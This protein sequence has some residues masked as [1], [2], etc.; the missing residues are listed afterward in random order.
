[1][2][3][4]TLP[5]ASLSVA[6]SCVVCPTDMVRGVGVTATLA[7]AACDTE[8]DDVPFFP[9]EVA[10][11]VADPGPVAGIIPFTS[12][13][14]TAELLVLQVIGRPG[15][16]FCPASSA[17]AESSACPPGEASTCGGVTTTLATGVRS[18]VIVATPD[19]PFTLAATCVEPSA[20]PVTTP[21]VEIVA[22]FES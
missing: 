11:I 6:V 8:M 7:T 22:I 17:V 19:L 10:V 15:S 13:V 18:T 4:S 3:F 16:G 2:P 14:A 1:G 9:S 20:T 21:A 12:T 5:P